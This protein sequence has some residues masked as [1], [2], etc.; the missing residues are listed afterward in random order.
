MDAAAHCLW[1]LPKGPQEG[2]SHTLAGGA[3]SGSS[4]N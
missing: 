2:T 4:T 1:R 3:V